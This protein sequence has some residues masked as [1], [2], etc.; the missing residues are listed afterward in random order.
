MYPHLS[1]TF[2][3]VFISECFNRAIAQSILTKIGLLFN[4]SPSRRGPSLLVQD[5]IQRWR[6]RLQITVVS[7]H[8]ATQ[9][10]HHFLCLRCVDSFTDPL[11]QR[12]QWHTKKGSSP[13]ARSSTSLVLSRTTLLSL[14]SSIGKDF[15]DW[16]IHDKKIRSLPGCLPHLLAKTTNAFIFLRQC[17]STC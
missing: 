8:S 4:P 16:M 5:K 14:V 13:S 12:R 2:C 11:I 7:L 17:Y 10:A 1:K 3:N 9:V 15:E 6:L